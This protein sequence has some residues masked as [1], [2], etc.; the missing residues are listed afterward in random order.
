MWEDES[1]PVEAAWLLVLGSVY[2]FT[3]PTQAQLRGEV[4]EIGPAALAERTPLPWRES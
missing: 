3:F 2:M 4:Q 1:Q